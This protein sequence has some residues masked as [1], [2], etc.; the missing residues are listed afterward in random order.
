[1][2]K[3]ISPLPVAPRLNGSFEGATSHSVDDLLDDRQWTC[4][5]I[6]ADLTGADL[7]HV[8][9]S[10]CRLVRCRL[11]GADLTAA[12]LVDVEL[13]DCELSGVALSE[14]TFTRVSFR[15]CR[16]SGAVFAA[17]KLRDVRVT[18]CAADQMMMRMAVAE[19]V[20]FEHTKLR[21]ADFTGTRFQFTRMFD[22]DLT[23]AEFSSV[24]FSDARFHGSDLSD[25]R[26]I[27]QLRGIVID[28]DQMY[29][30]AMSLLAAHEV[31][32]EAEREPE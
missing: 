11:T 16:L 17:A 25:V 15:S 5:E 12:R 1:M 13:V 32:V 14:S 30:F 7:A 22:C 9:V 10:E 20:T 26:G 27:Q 31:T 8:D 23:S 24:T 28:H 21:A 3:K 19:R 6:E 29:P 4:L 18:E 2:V